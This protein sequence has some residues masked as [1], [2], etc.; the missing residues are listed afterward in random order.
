MKHFR[1]LIAVMLTVILVSSMALPVVAFAEGDVAGDHTSFDD[2]WG[3]MTDDEGNV[4]WKKLPET[5]FNVFVFVR[6]FEVIASFFRNLLGIEAPEA[7]V[8]ATTQE[9]V[10]AVA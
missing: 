4:D 3:Q 9:V 2:F 6:I 7:E 10:S 1:K 5:L 8:P